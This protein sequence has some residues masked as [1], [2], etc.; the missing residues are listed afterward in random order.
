MPTADT[1]ERTSTRTSMPTK[2]SLAAR[3]DTEWRCFTPLHEHALEQARA[4][5]A[6]ATGPYA[7]AI[8]G[9]YGSGKSTL[10]FTLLR[11]APSLGAVALWDEAAPFVDRLVPAGDSILPQT[12]AARVLAW[13]AELFTSGPALDRYSD[14]LTRRGHPEIARA[15]R[16][17]VERGARRVVLL[18][19]EVEQAH[20]L[21]RKRIAADDGQPLRAL[22]DACGPDF[23]LLLSYAPESYHS[24]G[25]ADRGRLA[26]LPVPALDV[27]SI[28]ASLGLSRGEANFVWWASRGRARGVLQ[29]VRSIIEPLRAGAF[30]GGLDDL[31]DALDALP[32]VFGVP[33]VLRSGAS[34]AE[35]RALLDLV[36]VPSEATERGIVCSL[37][38]R[39]GLADRIRAELARRV[40]TSTDLLPVASELVAVLSGVA[41]EDDHAFLTLDDFCAALRAAEA[42]AIESGRQREP[43]ERFAPQAA[44]IFTSLGEMGPLR[45]RLRV[46]LATLTEDRFPS[47]FTDPYL[48]F[49]AGRAPSEAELERRFRELARQERPLLVSTERDFAVFASAD[50]LAAWIDS[51]GLDAGRDPVRAVLLSGC[52]SRPAAVELAE[53]AGRL[54]LLE[55]GPFHATFLKCLSLLAVPLA[56]L[57]AVPSIETLQA[58][59]GRDRQLARKIAWHLGRISLLLR[60]VKPRPRAIWTAASRFLRDEQFRG[61]L[62]RL[63]ADSP[64][65]LGLLLPLS[66]PAPSDRRLLTRL[67]R[68]CD[69]KGPLRRVA[70]T[71]NPGGRLSGA[72]VVVD[73]LL[74]LGAEAP[75]WTERKL[76]GA[77]ELVQLLGAFGGEPGSR[78]RLALWLFP[79][80]PRRLEAL[81]A[82]HAGALPDISEE[83][84][85]LEALQGLE[86]TVRRAGAILADLEE[87]TGRSRDS[88]RGLRLGVITDQVRANGG[89]I[90]QLRLLGAELR[91]EAPGQGAA[92]SWAR[93]LALW[94]SGVFAHRLL[95]GV[96][97]E[98]AELSEW[99]AAGAAARELGARA[100]EV[101][102]ELAAVGAEACAELLRLGRRRLGN[103]VETRES[104]AREVSLLRHAVNGLAS[105]ARSL[106]LFSAA[107]AERG[108]TVAQAMAAFLPEDDALKTHEALLRRI[109]ALLEDLEG[110]CPPPQGR[111]LIEYA[112]LL[113]RHAE[114]SRRERL[115]LRLEAALDL[116]VAPDL[117]LDEAAVVAIERT[118]AALPEPVA[119]A[120]RAELSARGLRDADTL[121][122]WIHEGAAKARLVAEWTARPALLLREA[123][124]RTARWSLRLEVGPELLREVDRRRSRVRELLLGLPGLL[125]RAVAEVLVSGAS[126]ASGALG[127]SASDEE[128]LYARVEGEV[129]RFATAVS[130]LL[131]QLRAAGMGPPDELAATTP[132][133]ALDLLRTSVTRALAERD[134]VLER[135][136]ELG[137]AIGRWGGRAAAIPAEV[138]L[139]QASRFASRE[140]ERLSAM[141]RERREGLAAWLSTAGLPARL[142]PPEDADVLGSSRL[143]E[144]VR[145][146]CARL[147]PMASALVRLGEAAP[148]A[149][150]EELVDWDA[151]HL[152]LRERHEHAALEQRDLARRT[153][154]A[155]LRARRL[156]GAPSP[157]PVEGL[158]L[159]AARSQTGDLEREVERLRSLRL[160][161]CSTG[162]RAAYAAIRS[163][164]AGSLP[165]S[166]AELLRLG[167]LRTLEDAR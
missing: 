73:E 29:A 75:R 127:A 121:E 11:E 140:A 85:Q 167:L 30:E 119:H 145:E 76:A 45:R 134:A 78:Q 6:G 164:D 34:H 13:A 129:L 102:R 109:P 57:T 101:E 69:T 27:A 14:E 46:P 96:E 148:P 21:L 136:R 52:A 39:S 93:Q 1:E 50:A 116:T 84:G 125:G 114:A 40:A 133:A 100:Q 62:G 64:A 155:T 117:L 138:N 156:G 26:Y 15:V 18:L 92:I 33:A 66:P 72:A 81:F 77:E 135:A 97:K 91:A 88:L 58:E 110:P 158:T 7:G 112:E 48:P 71:V 17:Q 115:R 79:E 105:L 113:R 165:E 65:L 44:L 80:D 139:P 130:G 3:L 163:G 49:E 36:P 4:V 5:A 162:A 87:C 122:R 128:H 31:G 143:L 61:A 147:E 51:G 123:D 131:D 67:A 166:V 95:S 153:E 19:D 152:L 37:A 10:A 41:D 20:E 8:V 99:E 137:A 111:S 118:W 150:D 126:S 142:L 74:P 154:A 161:D 24:V 124:E 16:A 54:C 12:F 146:R 59:L 32:G 28:Q 83:Q 151:A 86:R 2:K 70:R 141:L 43:I 106:Q 9:V 108:Q 47:P 42:R 120:L 132:Q 22:I 103:H 160:R 144:A 56:V 68:L 63:K 149:C 23:R 107:L 104:L 60:E 157:Q 35:T 53:A 94:I 89:P 159:A 25:D 38:D 90:E 82:F 55:V 98:Q